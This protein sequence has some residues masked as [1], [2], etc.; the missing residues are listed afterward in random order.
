VEQVVQIL[1]EAEVF[2]DA[3]SYEAACEAVII[4]GVSVSSPSYSVGLK[5]VSIAPNTPTE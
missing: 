3:D 4:E 1:I 2:V 5:Q